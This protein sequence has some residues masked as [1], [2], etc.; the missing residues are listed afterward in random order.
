MYDDGGESL[1]LRLLHGEIMLT[2]SD[3]KVTFYCE[4]GRSNVARGRAGKNISRTLKRAYGSMSK[5]VSKPLLKFKPPREKWRK[6]NSGCA[7][8]SKSM[9]YHRWRS[10]NTW[11]IA[12]LL[13]A[14]SV[15]RQQIC[16][17]RMCHRR[18]TLITD[19]RSL[20]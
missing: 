2:T 1:L 3:S 17:A 14:V 20:Y 7:H 13:R 18:M 6:R 10:T 15:R 12:G 16:L 9:V 8:S 19:V 4:T 5:R 11:R